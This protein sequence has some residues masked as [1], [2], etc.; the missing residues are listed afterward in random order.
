MVLSIEDVHWLDAGSWEVLVDLV[1]RIGKMRVCLLMTSRQPHARP[2][3]PERAPIDLSIRTLEPLSSES[4]LQLAH[5][6][7]TDLSA[8]IDEALGE[9][10]V[11]TGQGVPLFLR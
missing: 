2:M 1:D 8:T 11:H 4:S 6:I 10:F 9:W 3:P 5:A 7:G